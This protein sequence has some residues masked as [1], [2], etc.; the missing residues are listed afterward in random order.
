MVFSNK[1]D[2]FGVADVVD[3]LDG[4]AWLADFEAFAMEDF[5]V[6]DG[7]KVGEAVAELKLFAVDQDASIGLSAFF[8][9]LFRKRIAV[10]A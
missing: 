5:L 7:V 10:D 1:S 2:G 9:Y 6:A 4:I 3:G 8:D